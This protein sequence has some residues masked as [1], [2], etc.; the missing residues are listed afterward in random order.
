MML[1]SHNTKYDDLGTSMISSSWKKGYY[2]IL[3]FAYSF[4][5]ILYMILPGVRK[6]TNLKIH[7]ATLGCLYQD[8][9]NRQINYNSYRH[10]KS[11]HI[12]M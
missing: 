11:L 5:T 1:S 2:Y 4:L 12:I 8:I 9:S 10:T 3:K 6:H 7:Y